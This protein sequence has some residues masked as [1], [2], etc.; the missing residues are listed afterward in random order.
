MKK[1]LTVGELML[2][3]KPTEHRRIVQTDD[4]EATYGGS[5]ANVAVSLA[6]LGDKV[7]YF[8]KVPDNL[9]GN[10][11]LGTLRRYDVNINQVSR[12]G[13]RMGIYFFEQGASVRGTN[14]LYDRAH[15][16]FSQIR[17]QEFDWNTL[18]GG[19][20]YF[21]F[22][23]ITAALSSNIREALLTGCEYAAAHHI[24]VICDMNYRGKMWSYEKAQTEMAKFMPYVNVCLAN[25]EDFEATLGIQAFDGDMTHGISQKNSFASAMKQV[26]KKYPNCRVIASVI[27]DIRSV[28]D[29]D[30]TALM[31]SDDKIYSS[32]VYHMHVLEGVAGGDA[33]GAG[34]VHGLL[35]EMAPQEMIEY[36]I[37]ASV[38]KLTI[39]GDFNLVND[40]DIRAVMATGNSINR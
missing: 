33:F 4:F 22:S 14:V 38:S 6:L 29:S 19:K 13:E 35:H 7:E 39:P 2:R 12:G 26:H 30:W 3:F 28:E 21:Y 15:S 8:T 40:Q 5:E 31:L 10:A 36:A 34:L 9:L 32:A 17:A 18:L 24:T 25:D 27:R 23:G 1:I 16:S 11:A 20:D 37:A